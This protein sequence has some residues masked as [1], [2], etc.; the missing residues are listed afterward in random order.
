MQKGRDFYGRNDRNDYPANGTKWARDLCEFADVAFY[1][2][3]TG[4]KGRN[5]ILRWIKTLDIEFGV[6]KG[7][8]VCHYFL[9]LHFC[10]VF[11]VCFI[12]RKNALFCE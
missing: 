10:L 11:F 2:V 6:D 8:M 5:C 1:R 12:W 9:L 3:S 7:R 4:N